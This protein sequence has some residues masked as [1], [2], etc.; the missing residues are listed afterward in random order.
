RRRPRAA[1]SRRT[2]DRVRPRGPA[3]RVGDRPEP[4]LPR[5]DRL[6]HHA[7][8]GRG[9]E[10]REPGGRHRARRD[11]R[12][13]TARPARRPAPRRDP[14]PLPGPLGRERTPRRS[15]RRGAV[16][17]ARRGP[18]RDA[19]LDAP[20]ADRVGDGRRVRARRPGGDQ[21]DA[22]GRLPGA[23]RGGGGRR[24]SD[25]ALMLR[26]VRYTNKAFWRN[27]TSAFPL[28]FLV[29]F[30][31]LLG[32]GTVP[33]GGVLIKQSSYYVAAMATFSVITASYT[34]IAMSVTYQRDSGILKRVRGTPLPGWAYLVGRV[35]HALLVA[36]LLVALTA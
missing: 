35:I 34:N 6:P 30:T 33:I 29:I 3:K 2:D 9:R 7:L 28:M 1:V 14:H 8:H 26:Q 18:H 21:A 20:R 27:P 13:G 12:R 17:R 24:M 36:V 11:R 4:G 32:K 10:P 22:R 31:S 25:V 15:R 5:K 19:D 16:E 23:H